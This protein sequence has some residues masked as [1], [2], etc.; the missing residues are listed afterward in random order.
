MDSDAKQMLGGYLQQGREAVLWKLDGLGE[1]DRRRPLT[2][3][4]TN[5]IGLVKHLAG[6][7]ADYFGEVFG[8]PFPEPLDFMAEDAEENADMWA[9]AAE[10]S[11]QV[12]ALYRRVW[13]HSDATIEAL[14]LD[15]RGQV[16]WWPA[17][18]RGVTLDRILIHVATETHRHAGHADLVRELI[19]GET[20]LRPTAR[21]LSDRDAGWWSDY[22]ARLQAVADGAR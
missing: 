7:E 4:G 2:P 21:N 6:V 13:V 17:E 3:T 1:R 22:R 20:G 14:A 9:T 15:S 16:P 12:V 19:D 5:L 10:S 11:E 18:H 8:R